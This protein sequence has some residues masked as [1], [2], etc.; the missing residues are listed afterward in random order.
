MQK[1]LVG[2]LGLITM[3]MMS[4][5]MWVLILTP[6]K[7]IYGEYTQPYKYWTDDQYFKENFVRENTYAN[8]ECEEIDCQIETY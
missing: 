3:S 2:T 5:L 6:E 7:T 4:M 1:I 8:N